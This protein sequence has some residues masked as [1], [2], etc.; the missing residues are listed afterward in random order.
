MSVVLAFRN[1]RSSAETGPRAKYW[2]TFLSNVLP[3]YP[4]HGL[5]LMGQSTYPRS[6]SGSTVRARQSPLN[7]I[8]NISLYVHI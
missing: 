8:A 2:F 6:S 7:L 5:I 1:V 4:H 3:S